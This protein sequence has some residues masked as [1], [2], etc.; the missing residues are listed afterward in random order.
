M[1]DEFAGIDHIHHVNGVEPF[2][3]GDFSPVGDAH[4]LCHIAPNAF[5]IL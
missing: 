1:D 3:V 2:V 5:N 4:P